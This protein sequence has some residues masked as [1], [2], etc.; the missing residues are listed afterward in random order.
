MRKIIFP[1]ISLIVGISI[2]S[3]SFGEEFST[4]PLTLD[5]AIEEMTQKNPELESLRQEAEAAKKDYP[6][7]RF[8]DDPMVGVR[9]Y[10]V[11]FGGNIDEAEDIDY[12]VRQKFLAPG[13]IK[14]ASKV[15]YH[16]YLHHLVEV[17]G[18][19][20]VLIK[21][22][23]QTYYQLFSTQKIL[24]VNRQVESRLRSMIA[25]AQAKLSANEV[26]ATDAVQGQTELVKVLSDRE[27]LKEQNQTLH[28]K[29]RQLLVRENPEPIQLPTKLPIPHWDIPLET[30]LAKAQENHPNIQQT[31]HEIDKMQWEVK[32]AKREYLPDFN[33][34][35]EYVQRPGNT[36]DAWTGELM[37]NLPIIAK[38]KKLG[39]TKAEAQLASAKYLHEAAK[40]E[41]SFRVKEAYEKMRSAERILRLT[42]GTLLP[43]ARQG[44]EILSNSY[45]TGKTSFLDYLNATRSLLD[46]QE[47]EWK[48]YVNLGMAVADLEEAVG[49]TQEELQ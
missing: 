14:A 29:L 48:A 34:Q 27:V 2:A 3:R 12:I 1:L 8:W 25:A 49:M 20:R 13:K 46:A 5:A 23:K 7:S 17:R 33:A 45:I 16:Q 37:I 28:A 26:M 6:K 47:G 22:L 41:A 39:V 43:Q 18:K 42:Q 9:L 4:S 11:P 10:Q 31:Q 19:R 24:E 32:G 35:M 21:D 38:K 15:A 44:A 40:N 30:L 36:E